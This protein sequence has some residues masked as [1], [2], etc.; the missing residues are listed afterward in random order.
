MKRFYRK[1]KMAANV[2][3]QNCLTA[4]RLQIVITELNCMIL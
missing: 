2:S 1:S 3:I 4:Y